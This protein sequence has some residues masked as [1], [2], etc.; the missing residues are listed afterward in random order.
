MEKFTGAVTI[1][2]TI[3]TILLT[4]WSAINGFQIQ[5][6]K[7]A[8]DK[9]T[10][11]FNESIESR[12]TDRAD[13]DFIKGLMDPLTGSD[14]VKRSYA[15]ALVRFVLDDEKER[16]FFYA[17]SQS[18][19]SD[20]KQAGEE[21]LK[22]VDAQTKEKEGFDKLIEGDFNQAQK[23]FSDAE[24][25]APTLHNV[26][27]INNLLKEKQNETTSSDAAK[28]EVLKTIITDYAWKIPADTKAKLEKAAKP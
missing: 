18:N 3:L 25:T 16:A 22:K 19:N 8:I 14:T 20:L 4:I 23:S 21:G 24:K 2:S 12:T 28:K 17:M 10:T 7:D 26:S 13:Y 11:E 6:N 1:T 27:E 5:T 15:T 9:K